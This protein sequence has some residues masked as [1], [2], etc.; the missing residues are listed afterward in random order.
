MFF[1]INV[2]NAVG[3]MFPALW[4][5]WYDVN[6]DDSDYSQGKHLIF[7]LVIIQAGIAILNSVLNLLLFKKEPPTPPSFTAQVEREPMSEALLI[8]VKKV[9]YLL[10]FFSI[11][12][13]MA[14]FNALQSLVSY[15]VDFGSL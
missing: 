14:G 11:C 9:P 12:S 13:A 8:L 7:V 15:F 1:Q 3:T 10:L 6:S 5:N 2:G 4:F